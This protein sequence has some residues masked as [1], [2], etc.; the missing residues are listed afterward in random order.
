MFAVEV[1]EIPPKND[2]TAASTIV[3]QAGHKINS[4]SEIPVKSCWYLK[5]TVE[6]YVG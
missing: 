2:V 1:R 4:I 5:S 6:E 3:E